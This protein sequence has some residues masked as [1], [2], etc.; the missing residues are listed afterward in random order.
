M[1]HDP[2]DMNINVLTELTPEELEKAQAISGEQIAA[3]FRKG[4]ED[5]AKARK[6]KR[7]K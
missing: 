3:A 7:R 5:M 2:D 6:N 4:S 1:I